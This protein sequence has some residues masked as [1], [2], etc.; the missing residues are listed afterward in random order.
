MINY[1]KAAIKLKCKIENEFVSAD[2]A[3]EPARN[4]DVTCPLVVD[5]IFVT[6]NTAFVVKCLFN[7][8]EY[9]FETLTESE[10]QILLQA[11]LLDVKEKY[12]TT[13]FD[14]KLF[15]K[16]KTGYETIIRYIQQS[17]ELPTTTIE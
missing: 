5:P 10:A 4:G 3:A 7:G 16:W 8:D 9:D 1:Q 11:R 14:N 17:L 15:A 12:K 6:Y 13:K 2:K